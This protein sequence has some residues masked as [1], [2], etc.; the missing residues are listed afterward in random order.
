[1]EIRLHPSCGTRRK[2]TISQDEYTQYIIKKFMTDAGADKLRHI[3]TPGAEAELNELGVCEASD[4]A[5]VFAKSAPSH[6]GI[7]LYLMRCVRFE[8]AVAVAILGRYVTKWSK[9][10]DKALA[11]VFGY[12]AA[13]PFAVL[14]F[15]GDSRD[16]AFTVLLHTDADHGG[17]KLASRHL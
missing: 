8:T 6:I 16:S 17:D 3:Q 13:F 7:L 12:L 2:A 15:T 1:M 14:E 9:P 11:R 5:G 10:C 4:S